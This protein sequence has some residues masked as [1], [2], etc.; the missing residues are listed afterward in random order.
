MLRFASL[1]K[2]IGVPGLFASYESHPAVTAEKG[3]KITL[4]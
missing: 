3:I 2:T 1:C 4:E